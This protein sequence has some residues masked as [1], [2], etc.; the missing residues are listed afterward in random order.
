MTLK[1][2]RFRRVERIERL[3]RDHLFVI[4]VSPQ[5][6]FRSVYDN[7]G[8]RPASPLFV[9]ASNEI[10]HPR[11][12]KLAQPDHPGAHPRLDSSERRVQSLGNLRLRESVE[13]GEQERA[14]LL[15]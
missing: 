2:A 15:F 11:A 6:S 14:P 5:N 4:F 8:R 13:I 12:Q 9:K 7:S 3:S 10:L 1:R